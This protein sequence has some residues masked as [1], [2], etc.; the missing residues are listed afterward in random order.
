[1]NRGLVDLEKYEQAIL[2][3]KKNGDLNLRVCQGNCF[4][5]GNEVVKIYNHINQNASYLCDC[6]FERISFP[7]YYIEKNGNIHGEIMPYFDV[8]G[9]IYVLKDNCILDV[10]VRYYK[11]I[12]E[13]ICKF[14]NIFMIDLSYSNVLYDE[15]KG[16]Y[17]VDTTSWF[18][19][20]KDNDIVKR[21]LNH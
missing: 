3:R 10:L 15:E 13:E 4:I 12:C 16:F 14:A 6:V 19:D 1:M 21:I 7:Y 5:E 17:L 20:K 8:K 18:V 9:L 2:V 11:V